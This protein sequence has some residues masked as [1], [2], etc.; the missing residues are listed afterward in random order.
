MS[1]VISSSVVQADPGVVMGGTLVNRLESVHWEGDYPGGSNLIRWTME[2]PEALPE[3]EVLIRRG[4]L[5][6]PCGGG[7][8]VASRRRVGRWGPARGRGLVPHWGAVVSWRETPS[9]RKEHSP[10]DTVA[11]RGP[12][13]RAPLSGVRTPD[14]QHCEKIHSHVVRS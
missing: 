2:R 7:L 6:G 12:E 3:K 11:M 14:L 1:C 9:S 10:A 13:H 8:E 5:E 4:Q